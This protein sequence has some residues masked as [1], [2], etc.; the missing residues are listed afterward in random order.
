MNLYSLLKTLLLGNESE[1]V[2]KVEKSVDQVMSELKTPLSYI[3]KQLI[4]KIFL[5]MCRSGV[6]YRELS[7]YLV[8]F[9]INEM[10]CGL[11]FLAKS[12]VND[13]LIPDVDTL[14]FLTIEEIERLCNGERDPLIHMRARLR[15]KV[16]PKM[17]KY[18]FEEFIK[19]PEMKPRNVL[20]N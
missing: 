12:M 17:N 6:G 15:K 5:P 10:R 2:V 16:Y 14:F 20:L 13:G 4:R 19:G 9:I 8:I 7:K 18:K 11:R 1:L 3:R